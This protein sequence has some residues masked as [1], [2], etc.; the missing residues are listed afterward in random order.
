[1]NELRKDYI[2]DRWVIISK[3]RKA[4][5]KQFRK[6]EII[7]EGAICYFCPGN[8]NLTP[9]E[10]G[11][12]EFKNSWLIRWFPNKF[13]ALDTKLDIKEMDKK[14]FKKINAYGLYEVIAETPNHKHQLAD[15]S[16]EHIKELLLVYSLRIKELSIK[17]NIKYVLVF[18]NHG[19]DAGTSLIHSHTQIAALSQIP[20]YV[21]E[22]LN[23]IKKYK[24]CPYCDIIKLEEKSKRKIFEN[25][26]FLA[27]AP[28]ASR[29]NYEVWI[30]PKQHI[31]N[32]TELSE[33]E[34][35]ELA[36][37]LKKLL[38][39]INKLNVSYNF[40]LHYSPEK[41]NLHFHIEI[42][43]RIATWGGF[44]LSSDIVINS[45]GPEDA[46]KF[47]RT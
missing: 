25:K 19:R 1:M 20:K 36:R 34:L 21:Q 5:P 14:F 27:F 16:I 6:K 23:A 38:V 9:P 18:K 3:G 30:F 31:K 46:A 4:R 37:I 39:K 10:L 2:L 41:E 45:V 40:Y 24:D 44:E 47:Y 28:F 12:V 15:L 33:V 43:P 42:C 35:L 8:E 11:R 13:P 17:R 22:K 26:T 32:I 29:F 7:E